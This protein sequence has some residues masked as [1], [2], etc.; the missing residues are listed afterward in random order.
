MLYH[1]ILVHTQELLIYIGK[2]HKLFQHFSQVAHCILPLGYFRFGSVFFLGKTIIFLVLSSPDARDWVQVMHM[3]DK[4]CRSK[5][6]FC[7]HYVPGSS[8]IL[9]MGR[10]RELF[11]SLEEESGNEKKEGKLSVFPLF[12][13]IQVG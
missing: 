7:L 11:E 12:P 3:K 9:S 6:H 8:H 5:L 10:V 4:C 2:N 1:Y 13:W